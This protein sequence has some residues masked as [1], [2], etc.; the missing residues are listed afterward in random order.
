MKSDDR[1]R[2]AAIRSERREVLTGGRGGLLSYNVR[3]SSHSNDLIGLASKSHSICPC[4]ECL[5][6]PAQAKLLS[7]HHLT[8]IRPLPNCTSSAIQRRA[9]AKPCAVRLFGSATI[10]T[11]IWHGRQQCITLATS[12]AQDRSAQY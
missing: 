3:S 7:R 11:D 5:K 2:T 1:R 10:D 8:S 9:S 6:C 12:P 4:P